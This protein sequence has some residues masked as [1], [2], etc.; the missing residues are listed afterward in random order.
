MKKSFAVGSILLVVAAIAFGTPIPNGSFTVC[1]AGALE[2]CDFGTLNSLFLPTGNTQ[3]TGWTVASGGVRWVREDGPGP[4]EISGWDTSVASNGDGLINS[5]H[6]NTTTNNVPSAGTISYDLASAGLGLV[7]GMDYRIQFRMSGAP[8]GL[9]V[10]APGGFG[11]VFMNVQVSNGSP[12]PYV[13]SYL[14]NNLNTQM[15]WALDYYSFRYDARAG[16]HTLTFQ[17]NTTGESFGPAIDGIEVV[18]SGVPEP[19]TFSMLLGAGL[20]LGGFLKRRRS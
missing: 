16:F 17:S 6:L 10:G 18:D 5:I 1:T 12:N 20:L 14:A 3:L 4:G 11:Q 15:N 9:R 8:A 13:Y 7:D 2:T 19:G